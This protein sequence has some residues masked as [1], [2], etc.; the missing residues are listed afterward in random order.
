LYK[1]APHTRNAR[2]TSI[3]VTYNSENEITGLLTDLLRSR[4]NQPVIVID[5]ASQDGTVRLIKEKFPQVL[6]IKNETDVGYA[7]AVNQGFKLCD[8][9]YFFLLNPDIRI[10]NA[11]VTGSLLDVI[12]KQPNISA[13]APLQFKTQDQKR[14]LTLTWSYWTPKAF[15]LFLFSILKLGST[16]QGPIPVT[17]LNAGCLFIR[18]S[19]FK[20]V[21]MFNEK[22]H[23]YGEEPDLFLKFKRFNYRCLL[24]PA[25]HVIHQRESSM[26]SLS[27]R[28]YLAIK[29]QGSANIM[30]AFITG[31]INII[32]DQF[33]RKIPNW[34]FNQ[35]SNG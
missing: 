34:L 2:Y 28:E 19:A 13:V 20:H 25:V 23:L 15:T 17:Y 22:Y 24:L 3:I 33:F 21:G 32:R 31:W 18:S 35:N 9:D 8:T 11:K 29:M 6:L 4:D 5:N 7:R 27:N 30:D 1:S 14:N 16:Y 26:K 12:Q 10:P